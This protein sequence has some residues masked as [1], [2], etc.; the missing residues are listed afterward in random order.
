MGRYDDIDPEEVRRQMVRV[1]RLILRM[2]EEGRLLRE[3][4]RLQKLLGDLR[5][6]LFAYEVRCTAELGTP[7]ARAEDGRTE[8]EEVDDP[9]LSES[10]RVVQEALE[11]QQELTE[12]LGGDQPKSDETE[13]TDDDED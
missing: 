12:E 1:A 9:L 6:R 13:E 7:D 8:P 10:L 3:A 4:P 5:Q 11:R 2:E